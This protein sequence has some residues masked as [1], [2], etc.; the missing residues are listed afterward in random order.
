MLQGAGMKTYQVFRQSEP[1]KFGQEWEA[2]LL[3]VGVVR[4]AEGESV[5]E[6]AK[7]FCSHPII[8]RLTVQ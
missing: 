7:A 2:S 6:A 8:E 1:V 5:L 4:V 3:P